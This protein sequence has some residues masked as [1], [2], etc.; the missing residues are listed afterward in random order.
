[1]KGS[2]LCAA[3]LIAEEVVTILV[4]F[5][6]G[7][8]ELIWREGRFVAIQ[9]TE[10]FF[11]CIYAIFVPITLSIRKTYA[12]TEVTIKY[13]ATLLC[14]VVASDTHKKIKCYLHDILH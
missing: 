8:V 12:V 1:M 7:K 11:P 13:R 3:T 4:F 10:P 5:L 6:V 2:I 14:S 9:Q